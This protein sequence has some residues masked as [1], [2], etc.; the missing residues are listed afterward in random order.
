MLFYVKEMKAAQLD[1]KA[2]MNPVIL[3]KLD[4]QEISKV[5]FKPFMGYIDSGNAPFPEDEAKLPSRVENQ[6]VT[7]KNFGKMYAKIKKRE[8]EL[9]FPSM[10]TL[11]CNS[12]EI[13]RL[14][15]ILMRTLEQTDVLEQVYRH[16][17]KTMG[18]EAKINS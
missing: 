3:G 7:H 14:R 13:L 1:K 16:Q 4:C 6:P 17:A 18:L 9:V 11:M 2:G 12:V 15:H 8:E 10:L 5:D